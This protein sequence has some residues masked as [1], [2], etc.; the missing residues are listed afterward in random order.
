VESKAL[1][2]DE[3]RLHSHGLASPSNASCL[4]PSAGRLLCAHRLVS[5][6]GDTVH[7]PALSLALLPTT[8]GVLVSQAMAGVALDLTVSVLDSTRPRALRRCPE[9]TSQPATLSAPC[10]TPIWGGRSLPHP[11]YTRSVHHTS[12]HTYAGRFGISH[13]AGR[14]SISHLLIERYSQIDPALRWCGR[15]EGHTHKEELESEP[16]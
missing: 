8:R 3:D 11:V 15:D 5:P 12:F 9:D 13:A 2:F 6:D 1:L 16:P 14:C 10:A 4:C 7:R